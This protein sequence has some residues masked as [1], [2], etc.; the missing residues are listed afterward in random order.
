[1]LSRYPA[2]IGIADVSLLILSFHGRFLQR[3]KM[4]CK[5][6][7]FHT[8]SV[9]EVFQTFRTSDYQYELR[10]TDFGFLIWI[11]MPQRYEK[12]KIFV[13]GHTYVTSRFIQ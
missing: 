6:T 8:S 5:A 1:M 2:Q 9:D 11:S 7:T 12:G 3:V 10:V 4:I 13:K